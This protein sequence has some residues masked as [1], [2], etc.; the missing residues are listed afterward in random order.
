MFVITEEGRKCARSWERTLKDYRR[1]ITE[2]IRLLGDM[3][4]ADEDP[5][6][7]TPSGCCC[8]S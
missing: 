3:H 4:E 7:D 5:D 6:D 1:G 8:G 2:V